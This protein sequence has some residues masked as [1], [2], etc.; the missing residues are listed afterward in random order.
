MINIAIP[1]G[2]L[3]AQDVGHEY[4]AL[5]IVAGTNIR[6]GAGR[7]RGSMF[8][9][10]SYIQRLASP[11]RQSLPKSRSALMEQQ[12]AP[13]GNPKANNTLSGSLKIAADSKIPT[14]PVQ[15]VWLRSTEK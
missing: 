9:R 7:Q 6:R 8:F 13:G 12:T 2:T 15:H 5:H 1:N 11:G 14:Q 3:R 4:D 10:R